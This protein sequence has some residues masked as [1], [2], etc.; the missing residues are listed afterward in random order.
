[1]TQQSQAAVGSEHRVT[2]MTWNIWWRFGPDWRARQPRIVETIRRVDPD[3]VALQEVWGTAETSQAHEYAEQLGLHAAFA[4]P[5]LP[6]VPDPPENPDQE[7]V[8]MGVGLLSRWP[9]LESRAV[10]MPARHQSPPAA[11]LTTLDHPAGP[12]HVV[13]ACLEWEPAYNDDRVAQ[14]HAVVDLATDPTLDGPLPVFLAGDLN[15]APDSPV[16][17]PLHDVLTDAWTA[18]GGDPA[19]VTLASSHPSA[20]L[21]AEELIDQRIDH[22]FVR[23]GQPGVRVEVESAT[24]A[25]E[26]IED[27]F[28]SDHR[29]IVC[30]VGWTTRA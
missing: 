22:I 5:G 19:A 18:G 13:V 1:M 30:D 12:L 15:A 26:A 11:M 4:T 9:I 17:R 2:V 24:L 20:P 27:L 7:G 25:G 14:A 3:V 28:P 8:E 16:L 6:P 21:E 23:P 29:A 10:T